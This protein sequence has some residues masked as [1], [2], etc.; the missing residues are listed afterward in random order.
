MP[1]PTEERGGFGAFEDKTVLDY[2]DTIAPSFSTAGTIPSVHD[3]L[4]G[5]FLAPHCV[6][7]LIL[8]VNS[9][10]MGSVYSPVLHRN[11]VCCKIHRS[12]AFFDWPGRGA[13]RGSDSESTVSVHT[14][15]PRSLNQQST[16]VL[17]QKPVRLT[18]P[19]WVGRCPA[20]T[21]GHREASRE[22]VGLGQGLTKP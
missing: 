13:Q 14:K 17:Q 20:I 22:S 12:L 18:Q 5:Y 9:G 8:V 3:Q 15:I 19:D 1:G 4:K 16:D 10:F 6:R 21:T 7:R 2:H 11:F